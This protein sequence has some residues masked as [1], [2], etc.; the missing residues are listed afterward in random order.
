MAN[1][2]KARSERKKGMSVSIKTRHYEDFVDICDRHNFVP[3]N[4]VEELIIEFN[5]S[6]L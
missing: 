5:K 2:K 1:V 6:M 4:K 3:S